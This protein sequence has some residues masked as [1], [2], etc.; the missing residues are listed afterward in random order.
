MSSEKLDKELRI[1]MQNDDVEAVASAVA[2]GANVNYEYNGNTGSRIIHRAAQCLTNDISEKGFNENMEIF[3]AIISSPALE[4][5]AQTNSGETAAHIAAR[6]GN[7]EALKMLEDAGIDF[8][9][10]NEK[11]QSADDLWKIH[12]KGR[13]CLDFSLAKLSNDEERLTKYDNTPTKLTFTNQPRAQHIPEG[14]VPVGQKK[15]L[16]PEPASVK[17]EAS[18]F[19]DLAE[20][21][22]KT[23]MLDKIKSRLKNLSPVAMYEALKDKLRQGK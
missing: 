2:G 22:E 19:S 8:S 7:I 12:T 14:F 4:V 17:G 13:E 6:F 1:G 3:K 5:N 21:A 20:K 16:I 15:Q 18:K 9:I 11:G 10:K 23:S